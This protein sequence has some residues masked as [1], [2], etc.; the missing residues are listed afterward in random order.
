MICIQIH[1]EEV[2]RIEIFDYAPE[3]AIDIIPMII[4]E[5]NDDPPRREDG[6]SILD[7]CI[8]LERWELASKFEYKFFMVY[9][10]I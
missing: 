5:A 7:R 2:F 9:F 8:I 6:L 10:N 1:F 3:L 4:Q